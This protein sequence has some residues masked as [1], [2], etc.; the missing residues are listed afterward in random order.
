VEH[1]RKKKICIEWLKL[2]VLSHI[3]NFNYKRRLTLLA[4]A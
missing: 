1:L 4:I 2:T 3:I